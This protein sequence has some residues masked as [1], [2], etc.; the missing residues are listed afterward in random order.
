MTPRFNIGRIKEHINNN[1]NNYY[2]YCIPFCPP[3]Y[4][5]FDVVGLAWSHDPESFAVGS[6]TTGRVDGRVVKNTSRMI[7]KTRNSAHT[8]YAPT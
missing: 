5:Y 2:Y 8:G 6:V 4:P 7:Y 3:R 1:N